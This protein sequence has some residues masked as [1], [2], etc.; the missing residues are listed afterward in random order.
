MQG[1]F[2]E[3]QRL[4]KKIAFDPAADRLWFVGDL[5]NRGPKSLSVLRYVRSLGDRA[6]TVLGNHDLHLVATRLGGP[7]KSK[8]T[9][10]DILDADDCDE[11]IDW[12]RSRP[13]IHHEKGWTLVHAGLPPQWSVNQA[14]EICGDAARAIASRRSDKFL[15]DGMY[16]DQPDRWSAKLAGADRL[17]YVVNTCTRMRM[18]TAD[19]RVDLRFK[20]EIPDAPEGLS[21]WFDAPG[22][23]SAGNRIVFGHW[24]ALGRVEWKAQKAWGLDTGCVWGRSLTALRLSDRKVCSVKSKVKAGD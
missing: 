19:G 14:L 1:C 15:V 8:D 12:L 2:D 7:L 9:F 21:A 23:R 13:L 11:L 20:G 3:L 4:L 18:V 16:G 24:S 17:R 22:R 6:V 10:Q 5:V